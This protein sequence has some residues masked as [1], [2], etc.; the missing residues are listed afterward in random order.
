MMALVMA[1]GLWTLQACKKGNVERITNNHSLDDSVFTLDGDYQHII[2]Y[3]QSLG[4]GWEAHEALTTLSM[5]GNFM[6][7]N[8]PNFKYASGT[9]N[10]N[11]LVASRWTNGGEQP[12]VSAVNS[13]SYHYRTEVR[14]GM[15]FI[16]STG[17]EGG[18]SIERLSKDF[19]AA[20]N[21]Y[22]TTFLQSLTKAKALVDKQKLTI[23]C[24]A[25]IYMQGEFNYAPTNQG[26]GYN[27][28]DAVTS[29]EDYK[30]LLLKLK[31]NMQEDIMQQYQQKTR[32]L[33]FIY[34]VAGHYITNR[35]MSINMAQL[36][37]A[38]ENKD[39]VLLNPTYFTSDYNG[40]HLSSNGYRWYGEA[41]AKSLYKQLLKKDD[42]L[43]IYPV[44]YNIS[45]STATIEMHVPHLPLV[46]DSWTTKLSQNYGFA[47]FK[48]GQE[49]AIQQVL[50]EGNKVNL[51]CQEP[52]TG[53]IEISYAGNGRTG[54][55]NLRDSEFFPSYY[56]Y[57]DLG[58]SSYQESYTPTKSKSSSEKIYGSSYPLQNWCVPF[59]YTVNK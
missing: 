58:G 17:G 21:L 36:E 53:K 4:M 23:Q 57:A 51:V 29:K 9:D 26:L 52:L 16:G 46:L 1:S 5:E 59:Y 22:K 54:N 42:A 20:D 13:L 31:N 30:K 2:F 34:Q 8:N 24:P 41:I 27:G 38:L 37:F 47:V 14:K 55:G 43:P 39:V 12:I 19:E 50:L 25:I 15:K 35:E 7:G 18:M 33:F 6:L 11:P 56:S 28:G 40:G 3:G 48:N 10:L 45:G 32:P 44:S 49:I